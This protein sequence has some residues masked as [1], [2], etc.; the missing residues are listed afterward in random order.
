MFKKIDKLFSYILLMRVGLEAI[1]QLLQ[2]PL[3]LPA[4]KVR[5]TPDSLSL[6]LCGKQSLLSLIFKFGL[7]GFLNKSIKEFLKHI[8]SS[9][10]TR[11]FPVKSCCM[12]DFF[13]S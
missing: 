2:A 5:I 11:F 12:R 10:A 9:T 1:I 7:C 13:S 8:H 4:R 3:F 6:L